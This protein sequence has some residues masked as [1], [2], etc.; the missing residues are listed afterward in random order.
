MWFP[1]D[2]IISRTGLTRDKVDGLRFGI[3]AQYYAKPVY[4]GVVEKTVDAITML[5]YNP[6]ENLRTVK[7]E[8]TIAHVERH[9]S[10][11]KHCG[12]NGIV[13]RV[14]YGSAESPRGRP[15]A[16]LQVKPSHGQS[17]AADVLTTI[18]AAQRQ[19]SRLEQI[20]YLLPSSGVSLQ[21]L[22]LEIK[23]NY[24]K[25]VFL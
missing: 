5:W 14:G 22:I 24:Q 15:S 1:V 20:R 19:A 3:G 8:T 4:Y 9:L 6:I 23:D 17:V 25:D 21:N 18:S 16:C 11:Y 12:N 2:Q 7:A 10:F 13:H